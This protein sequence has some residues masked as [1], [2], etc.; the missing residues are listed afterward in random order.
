MDEHGWSGEPDPESPDLTIMDVV[1]MLGGRK[2]LTKD[3]TLLQLELAAGARERL[4]PA[5]SNKDGKPPPDLREA[6]L[7]GVNLSGAALYRARLTNALLD[8]TNLSGADLRR[9]DFSGAHL[10]GADLIGTN[11]WVADLRR[12]YLLGAN[13]AGA[14]LSRAKLQGAWLQGADLR[15]ADL[16]R[17]QMSADIVWMLP[18]LDGATMLG[19]IVW[20]GALLTLVDW[21]QVK[22]LGDET[23]IREARQRRDKK[24]RIPGEPRCSSCLSRRRPRAARAGLCGPCVTLPAAGA[25]V[26]TPDSAA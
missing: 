2:P 5:E 15:G 4:W 25:A 6:N 7:Q 20:N 22:C 26:G 3:E 12:A 10:W 13:L 1:D 8:Q 23:R 16:Q 19:D 9:A 24:E 21:K 14:N 11:L 18:R 17:S